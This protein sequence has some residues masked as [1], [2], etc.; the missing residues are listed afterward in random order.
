MFSLT[1]FIK[2]NYGY[3]LPYIQAVSTFKTA[4]ILNLIDIAISLKKQNGINV[5]IRGVICY[6]LD[7]IQKPP[8]LR[9]K[10]LCLPHTAIQFAS[11]VPAQTQ[12]RQDTRKTWKLK[13]KQDTLTQ[14]GRL[15]EQGEQKHAKF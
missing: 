4:G 8:P 7:T 2:Y 3:L 1:F 12:G 13:P 11:Y 15:A 10:K 5:K 14:E 9:S 6:W